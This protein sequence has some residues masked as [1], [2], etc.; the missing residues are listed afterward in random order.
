MKMSRNEIIFYFGVGAAALLNEIGIQFNFAIC[1]LLPSMLI[2]GW[3]GYR[4]FPPSRLINDY[5]LSLGVFFQNSGDKIPRLIDTLKRLIIFKTSVN[6]KTC[7]LNRKIPNQRNLPT[8]SAYGF[9]LV[10]PL[11]HR[12]VLFFIIFPWVSA[13]ELDSVW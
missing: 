13:S 12:L 9:P 7:P 6:E 11:A 3:L 8:K 5:T 1:T 10:L 2:V 4:A